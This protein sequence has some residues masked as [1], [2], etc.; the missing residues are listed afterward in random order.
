MAVRISVSY[1]SPVL[2]SLVEQL[3]SVL[4]VRFDFQPLHT[5]DV[6]QLDFSEPRIVICGLP[7]FLLL[8]QRSFLPGHLFCILMLETGEEFSA[9]W[10]E[11]A[12]LMEYCT[13][14]PEP[15]HLTF[16]LNRLY[17]L[18]F[19]YQN[20]HELSLQLQ[21]QQQR[22]QDLNEIGAALST[23]RNL[24]VLMDKILKSSMAITSADSGSLY[25]VE[26]RADIPEEPENPFANKGLRFKWTRNMS[27]Q[28]DFSEFSMLINEKSI[29]GYVALTAKP[30]NIPDVYCLVQDY[31]FHFNQSFD[32]STGYHSHSMLTVPMQNPKGEI[33]GILQML[34]KKKHSEQRLDLNNPQHLKAEILEFTTEDEHLLSSLAG[35]AAVAIENARLYAAIQDLFEGFIRASV[36]AIESRDPTTSGHSERV[37]VLT[38]GLAEKLDHISTGPYAGVK[39]SPQDLK[40]IQYAS[41]LHDFG[42][43]GVREHVLVKA[44]KL[45]PNELDMIRHR[46]ELIRKGLE[47]DFNQQKYN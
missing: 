32:L 7:E 33:I 15:E 23:E 8:R 20:T 37:A 34:N 4:G 16:W 41:L 31:P 21:Q 18:I 9:D 11:L 45:Y 46:F 28:L 38:V 22:L 44:E 36:Q 13:G 27:L 6:A 12:W 19:Q 14:R 35:Q 5:L 40:E 39:F 43:I 25:L 30:L 42:K 1:L 29:A 47:N 3:R 24:D 10:A 17:S 26:T 2:D